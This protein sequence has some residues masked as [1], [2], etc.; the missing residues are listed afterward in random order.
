M[1]HGINFFN[2]FDEKEGT[3]RT[4]ILIGNSSKKFHYRQ[5][6]KVCVYQQE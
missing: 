5:S 2:R 4:R 6:G 1:K 3:E